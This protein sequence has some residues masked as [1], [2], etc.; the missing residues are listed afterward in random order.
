[1]PVDG[2]PTNEELET[3]A[4]WDYKDPKGWFNYI[5]SLWSYPDYFE[6]SDYELLWKIST[7]GWSGNEDMINSMQDNKM[8]WMTTW[9]SSTRGGH[10][11]FK[12]RGHP[13]EG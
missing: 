6:S 4:A 12:L 5:D 1:M 11:I 3:I 10:Y 8:L 9:Y 2:Y 13:D 7:G